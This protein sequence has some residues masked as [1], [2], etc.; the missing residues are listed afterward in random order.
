MENSVSSHN[1][2]LKKAK[3]TLAKSE[4]RITEL[5]KIISKLYED[6]VLGK[7]SDERFATLSKGYESEQ[8]QIKAGDY[9]T[10]SVCRGKGT[11]VC[12]YLSILGDC[13]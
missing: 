7:I 2:E 5:D 6:N 1:E 9:G 13:S 12:G 8:E 11:E 10:Y 4:K 3:K